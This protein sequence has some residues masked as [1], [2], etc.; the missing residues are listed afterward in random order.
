M[1]N[2]S[3]CDPN[4]AGDTLED[5]SFIPGG[6][7]LTKLQNSILTGI[8][9]TNFPEY[10]IDI[11]ASERLR[12]LWYTR[13]ANAADEG[14]LNQQRVIIRD[15]VTLNQY[16]V[17]YGS[18][19]WHEYNVDLANPFSGGAVDLSAVTSIEIV[20]FVADA[21]H[22]ETEPGWI[23][24]RVYYTERDTGSSPHVSSY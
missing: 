24:K 21:A 14:G 1:G 17:L 7:G 11:S 8:K 19:G 23:L 13:A 3:L 15:A 6:I 5:S 4:I 20:M 9:L 2:A 10:P 18:L 12:F 16:I 22:V